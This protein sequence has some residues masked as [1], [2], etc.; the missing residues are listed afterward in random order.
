MGVTDSS[1]LLDL[2]SQTYDAA[3]DETLWA[4]IAPGLAEPFDS[5]SCT[6]HLINPRDSKITFLGRTENIAENLESYAA[7]YD[8]HDLWA[9]TGNVP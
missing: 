6:L 7:Y 9:I 5:P 2:I 1:R 4:G 3:L 8:S